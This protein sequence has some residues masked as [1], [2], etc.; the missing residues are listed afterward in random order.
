M[1]VV[2]RVWLWQ[3]LFIVEKQGSRDTAV[4]KLVFNYSALLQLWKHTVHSMVEKQGVRGFEVVDHCVAC[5]LLKTA[6]RAVK[7]YTCML[8]T[9]Y[10]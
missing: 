3:Y 8:P 7:D 1:L 4:C 6:N 2:V 10:E 5:M 9:V